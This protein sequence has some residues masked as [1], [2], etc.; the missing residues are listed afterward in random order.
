MASRRIALWL[1]AA[2]TLVVGAW[3]QFAPASF[4]TSFPDGRG[5]VAIDGPYNEHLVRD[6][7]GLN[8]ALTLLAAWAAVRLRRDLIRLAAA[9]VLVYAVPHIVYHALHLEGLGAADAMA[10]IGSLALMVALPLWLVVQPAPREH[11]VPA[12]AIEQRPIG[13]H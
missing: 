1:L 3:A 6:V 12:D 9:A 13:D 2:S 5:W 8:L 11:H 4:Y 10:N 7:G